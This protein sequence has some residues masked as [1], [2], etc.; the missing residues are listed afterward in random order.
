MDIKN[1]KFVYFVSLGCPKNLVDSEVML[2]A[3][4]LAGY[5]ITEEAKKAQ[6]III[7]TCSFIKASK[8]EAI[9]T[10]LEMSEYK[11]KGSC[12]ILVVTGCLS[13][14]YPKELK[15]EI[16]EVD[17]FVGTGEYAKIVD[18][19]NL[20]K[21]NTDSTDG[22]LVVVAKP[23]FIHS[24]KDFRL[25]T[26]PG[27]IGYL[28][29]SEGCNRGCTFCIIPK[30]RGRVR[31]RSINSLV[32]EAETLATNGVRELILV[33]QDLTQYGVDLKN[34]SLEKLLPKLCKIKKIDR[35]RLH[36]V[37]PDNVSDELVNLV[38][39]EDKILKYL[40]IPIQHTSNKVLKLM[41]R[42]I[43]K[44]K[45]FNLI[46]EFKNKVPDVAIRTSIIAGFP[47]E[48]DKDFEELC[49]DIQRLDLDY[50]G[51]FG[52]SKEEGTRA[53]LSKSQVSAGTIKKRVRVLTKIAEECFIKKNSKLIGK[54]LPALIVGSETETDYFIKGRL[55][56]QSLEIDGGVLINDSDDP[57]FVKAVTP[58]DVVLVKINEIL[59][60]NYVGCLHK[61]IKK[62][63]K[64]K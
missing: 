34:V 30:L 33:A 64:P 54:T 19:I 46:N 31:S 62:Y 29:I 38:V 18:H 11:T 10:I 40:D 24:E 58:G 27:Y 14:H 4:V 63:D 8:E 55:Y 51:V 1:K 37:Y 16:P 35:I 57:A 36:Y 53:A 6:I 49:A 50:V 42:K 23:I 20:L 39:R 60:F 17:L 47:G 26:G 9:S 43:S 41:N 5:Q 13:Q 48:S 44:D 15:S 3:L 45:I 52:Y 2:G 61:I 12:K 25:H 56:S 7:N 59:P 28:K 32:V 21:K 22:A